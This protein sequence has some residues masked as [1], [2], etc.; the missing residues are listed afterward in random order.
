MAEG[1]CLCGAVR[2]RVEGPAVLAE[3]CH[4]AMCRRAVGAPVV[5]LGTWARERFR[6]TAGEPVVHASS[7]EA[8][9]SFCGRCGTSL[10]F[11]RLGA[12]DTVDV[13]LASLDDPVPFAPTAHIWTMSRLPWLHL[14]D[15]LPEHEGGSGSDG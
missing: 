7:D 8:Q 5:G 2:F 13:T 1:G 15:G 12:R 11:E 10:L 6:W 3:L 14:D 9:R 4:C